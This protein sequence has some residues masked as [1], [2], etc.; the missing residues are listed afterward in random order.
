LGVAAALE[1]IAIYE[2]E[3][4]IGRAAATAPMLQAGLHAIQER[5]PERVR[6]TRSLG[7][8]AALEIEADAESWARLG[9]ALRERRVYMFLKGHTRMVVLSPPLCITHEE[10]NLGLEALD[11]SIAAMDG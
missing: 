3:D 10:L 8:L 9:A 2:E 5:H 11:A 6:F 1:A 7:L 4:L